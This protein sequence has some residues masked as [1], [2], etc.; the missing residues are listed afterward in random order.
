[1]DLERTFS[2]FEFIATRISQEISAEKS[3]T[4]IEKLN[5]NHYFQTTNMNNSYYHHPIVIK[6]RAAKQ[7]LNVCMALGDDMKLKELDE[8]FKTGMY[9]PSDDDERSPK[10]VVAMRRRLQERRAD[11]ANRPANKK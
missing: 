5:Q 4:K 1:L 8:F 7:D 11:S 3:P 2:V 6:K 10:Q 9:P